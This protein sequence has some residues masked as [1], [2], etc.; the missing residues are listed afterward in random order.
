MKLFNILILQ[1]TA[2]C[3]LGAR[4]TRS[5]KRKT[6]A[7]LAVTDRLWIILKFFNTIMGTGTMLITVCH[8]T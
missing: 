7:V 8:I 6:P 1:H 3:T 5:T 2:I 4:I